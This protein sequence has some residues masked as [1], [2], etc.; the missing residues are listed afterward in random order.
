[1]GSTLFSVNEIVIAIILGLIEGL[2][3]FLPV[4]STAHLRIAQALMGLDLQS[5]FWKLFAVVI[6]LGAIASVLFYFHERLRQIFS[7]KNKK[8]VILIAI[9]FCATVAPVLVFR[10]MIS[11]NLEDLSLIAHALILGGIAMIVVDRRPQKNKM[12]QDLKPQ[13]VIFVGFFQALSA[14][15]PGLSRSMSTI[16]GGQLM[17]L[18]RKEALE[19]SFLLSLPTML[20]ATS[21]DLFR[22]VFQDPVLL[23]EVLTKWVALLAGIITSFIVAFLVISWFMSWVRTRGFMPFAIYRILLG[24]FILFQTHF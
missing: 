8:I 2:T 17:G 3:E 19:F 11:Q 5:E 13:A 4:S 9:A 24:A 7:Q 6:Q 16:L 23:N 10:K 18:S 14:I 12:I 20:A 15:F 22:A 1:M 21:Y